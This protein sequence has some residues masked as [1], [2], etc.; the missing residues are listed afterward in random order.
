[1][2]VAANANMRCHP[3]RLR[4]KNA[5]PAT[6]N[7]NPIQSTPDIATREARKMPARNA[8]ESQRRGSVRKKDLEA[9]V[10]STSGDYKSLI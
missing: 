10:F 5:I 8:T 2:Q 1:M 7:A 9:T 6:A 3:I 4:S